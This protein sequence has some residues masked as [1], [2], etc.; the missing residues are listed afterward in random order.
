M[1]V[2]ARWIIPAL[3]GSALLALLP[4]LLALLPVIALL[5]AVGVST[6]TAYTPWSVDAGFEAPSAGE[7]FVPAPDA[8]YTWPLPGGWITS[9]FG[10]R[11]HRLTRRTSFHHGIDIGAP[12][13]APVL[14]AGVGR[15]VHAGWLGGYGLAVAIDHGDGRVSLYGHLS[16]GLVRRGDTVE[17]GQE[18]GR[19]GSTGLS[20]GPH[21]HFEWR[22]DGRAVD[23]LTFYQ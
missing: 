20:T 11:V 12:M 13:G 9:P 19:V 2:S 5:Q 15:I 1:V 4:L 10:P 7:P 16:A 18:I 21:L 6:D 17:A 23:P 22:V 3:L 8:T 14:A